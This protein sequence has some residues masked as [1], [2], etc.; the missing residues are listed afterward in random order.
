MLRYSY[1]SKERTKTM[2][3]QILKELKLA[4]INPVGS[5][6]KLPQSIER[7]ISNIKELGMD[8]FNKNNNLGSVTKEI[9]LR[10]AGV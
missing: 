6:Q 3:D 4:G 2:R 1:K 7:H 10:L 9:V 8:Y 5:L